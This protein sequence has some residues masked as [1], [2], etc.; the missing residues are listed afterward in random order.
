MLGWI[1]PGIRMDTDEHSD[2]RHAGQPGKPWILLSPR[3]QAGFGGCRVHLQA[4]YFRGE[5]SKQGSGN[6]NS[7]RVA[8][9]FGFLAE[10]IVRKPLKTLVGMRAVGFEPRFFHVFLR[11]SAL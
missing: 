5:D 8:M 10:A 3:R 4:H 1:A 7:L 2:T 9:T 6:A 11:K